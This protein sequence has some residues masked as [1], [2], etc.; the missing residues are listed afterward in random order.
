MSSDPQID[1]IPND[2]FE[3]AQEQDFQEIDVQLYTDEDRPEPLDGKRAAESFLSAVEQS[4]LLTF[5]GEQ[6]LFK[7]L[8]FLRFRA[9]ALQATLKNKR[10]PKKTEK[11]IQRLVSEAEESRGQIACANLRLVASISRRVSSSQDEFD[12]FFAEANTIL[13][14]AIDKFDYM[15]GYRF[16][17]YVTHSIQRHLYR[18]VARKK[19]LEQREISE[20]L[21]VNSAPV[22]TNKNEPTEKEIM[23]AFQHVMS[24]MDETL[25]EREQFII[26]GR[27][28]LD[29][30]GKGLS[31]RAMGDQLG[32]SKERARQIFQRGIEKLGAVAKSYEA[33]FVNQ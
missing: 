29:G 2:D 27:F 1:F 24:H 3:S 26:R 20:E 13:L 33:V 6:F 15:R 23:E 9:N 12:E 30:D 32:I 16:S 11:E 7:R 31:L 8:N 17:T 18:L 5:E 14:K 4:R 21:A 19:K 22:A 25:D 10:R 28:G